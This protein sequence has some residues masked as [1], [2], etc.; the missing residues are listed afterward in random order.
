Q[1]TSLLDRD[2]SGNIVANFNDTYD[3]ADR[4]ITED[5]LG[6]TT[7][8][9]YDADNRLISE[10]GSSSTINYRYDADG[11]R[12]GGNNVVG[13]G[14]QLM[15]DGTWNYS[16]DADGNLTAKVGVASGPEH[17]LTWVYTYDHK[18]HMTSA[19]ET[20]GSTTLRSITYEYDVFGNRIE[21]D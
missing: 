18:N 16:Y 20:Q 12:T 1:I 7:T 13:A 5:N 9:A 3:L 2:G 15:S 17:G 19:V 21:E 6:L 8:Y 11:N 4:L 10:V 14:N